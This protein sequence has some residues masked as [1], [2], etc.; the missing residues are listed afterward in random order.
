MNSLLGRL[1]MSVDRTQSMLLRSTYDVTA[2]MSNP[3]RYQ[4]PTCTFIP[5]SDE[6]SDGFYD[7]TYTE[8]SPDS[9][10]ENFDIAPYISAYMLDYAKINMAEQA[11][12]MVN[13]FG[14]EM[15]YTDTKRS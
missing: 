4:S 6:S 9:A 1:N 2:V 8:V 10:M 11:N 7:V 12:T 13:D 14:L 15:L 5:N 3:L